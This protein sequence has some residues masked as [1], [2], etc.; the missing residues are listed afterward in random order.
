MVGLISM[1]A[2]FTVMSNHHLSDLARQFE[3]LFYVHFIM[4]FIFHIIFCCK[5]FL[6]NGIRKNCAYIANRKKL[7]NS[8]G[9]FSFKNHQIIQN[10]ENVIPFKN[11]QNIHFMSHYHKLVYTIMLCQLHGTSGA[12]YIPYPA[13]DGHR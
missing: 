4:A 11:M 13:A 5:R 8:T 10:T 12:T 6:L 9:N 2:E 1:Q 3:H 7:T